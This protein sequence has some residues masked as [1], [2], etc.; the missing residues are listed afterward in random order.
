LPGREGEKEEN[1]RKNKQ[2]PELVSFDLAQ[3]WGGT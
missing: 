1:T 2:E 3:E